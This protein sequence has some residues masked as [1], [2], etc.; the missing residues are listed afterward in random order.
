MVSAYYSEKTLFIYDTMCEITERESGMKYMHSEWRARLEHWIET[1]KKDLYLPLAPIEVEAFCTMDHMTLEAASKG[2]FVSMAPGSRWGHTWEYCWMRGKIVLPKSAKGRRIAMDLQTGGETT[3]FVDGRSF[4]TRRAEWVE[5]PHHYIV[6]NFLTDSGVPGNSYDLMLEV[7][8]GH[9]YPESPLGGCAT[10]PVL[11]GSYTDPKMEGERA[12]LGNMT[13]GIWN[14]DAYQLYM[15]L[16]TLAL[17]GDQLD[18]ESLRADHVADALERATLI[19]DFEQPLEKRIESYRAAREDLKSALSAVNGSTAPLFY[20]IGN[21]HLDLAW[22]WPMAETHRKTSRTFAQQ[23]RLIDEYPEYKYLQSQPAAYEMCRQHYPE[24]FERIVEAA[25]GGQ[26]I[27]EG[28]MWVE[29]DTNM[30]SGESLIRQVLHGKRYFKDVFGVDS[31]VLW[32]PDT[33]GYSAALPQILNRTGVKYL[34]TQKI[35]WSYN[36]GD[37][38]P[39]HYFT[40]QGADGSCIDSFLPTSYTYRTDPKEICET[41]KKRVQKRDLD[42]FLLPFGYGDGG[43]GPTR[44]HIEYLRREGN[45]EGMPRVKVAGP[46]EFFE[47]MEKAGSRKHTYVGEL[48]F[49]AHRG[50]YTSQA[51][52]KRGNRLSE[53]ALREAEMWGSLA[54]IKGAE[55]PLARMDAAW[56]KLLLNQFHDILPGSSIAKVYEDARRDHKWIISEAEAVRDDALSFLCSGDGITVFNSLSFERQSLIHLPAEYAEGAMTVDGTGIPTQLSGDGVLALVRVPACGAVTLKP[57]KAADA[58]RTVDGGKAADAG[59]A[60]DYGNPEDSGKAVNCGK[61]DD[62]GKAADAGKAEDCG[63]TEDTEKPADSGKTADFKESVT[64]WLIDT[65]AVMENTEVRVELNE[66]GEVVS[67]ID[68]RSGRENAAGPMNRLLMYK[69][70][71][72]LFDAWDIDSNYILQSVDIEAP[73]VLSLIEEG[74][75][76]AVFRVS[77]KVLNSDFVQDIILEAGSRRLDFVTDVNW[78]ELHRLLKVEFPVTVQAFEGINEIQ[79]GYMK[80]PTHRSRLYDSDRFEVCNQ[81]Y[82]ALCDENH[83]TA[84]LNDCK[85]GISMNG[86]SLQLTL[87]RAGASPEMRADNGLHRF[88]YAFTAWEGSFMDS[89]VVREAYDLNVPMTV[90]HGV[91]ESFSAFNVEAPNVF[92]DTVKPAEDGSGDIILRLY[93]AK[94]ADT[95]T[96]LRLSIPFKSI[97]ICDMLENPEEALSDVDG[98]VTLDFHTFEVKTLRVT[99]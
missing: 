87:L 40:W 18:E 71:P 70:V 14:E 47:D 77:R 97:C 50:V 52:I 75:L 73:V 5:V 56:K 37:Q 60:E 3:V 19:I 38:F 67:F 43:G 62:A 25:K 66:R 98:A 57:R 90:T 30:T 48:Y 95:R 8:A 86:N 36:E 4:G 35:F 33:F 54:L 85:Y 34:V 21:A 11:P 92:I 27:P 96:R 55:Y 88:T 58:G 16:N 9:Y 1:L 83:G 76:R 53:L 91:C 2:D 59:K 46:V 99:R 84:V 78:R 13:Y 44:D 10:G 93:E 32:L 15:D 23:L 65:G 68:R 64:A 80:R 61:T 81:R 49:S 39:Y 7:Y 94:R 12:V 74:P 82:S 26:W 51:A 89:P 29:P 41:W 42:A 28:A 22:L 17:L 24:L 31:V 69:D 72:R 45:L 6:D 63:K 20:A 79:F